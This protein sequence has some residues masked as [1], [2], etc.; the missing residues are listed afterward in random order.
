MIATQYAISV[1]DC[2]LLLQLRQVRS[3]IYVNK[4]GIP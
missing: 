3:D 4:R 2:R 1:A